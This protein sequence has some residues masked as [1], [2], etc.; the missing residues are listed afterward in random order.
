MPTRRADEFFGSSTSCPERFST[1][2][3][4][5]EPNG[6]FQLQ[7]GN[8]FHPESDVGFAFNEPTLRT[9][10]VLDRDSLIFLLYHTS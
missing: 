5:F 6:C 10:W 9:D 4:C 7:S 1:G 3:F 2:I 8:Y